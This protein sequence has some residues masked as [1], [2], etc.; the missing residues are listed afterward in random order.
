[1]I[2]PA[3]AAEVPTQPTVKN[4]AVKN[5]TKDKRVAKKAKRKAKPLKEESDDDGADAV[6]S[7]DPDDS[8]TSADRRSTK[9][10]GKRRIVER[11]IERDYDVEADDRSGRRRVTV[12]R[13]G[14]GLFEGLFGGGRGREDDD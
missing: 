1:L 10:A 7:N 12:N 6:A 14:G 4:D 11:W 3:A 13:R 2:A 8:E 9:P 5:D